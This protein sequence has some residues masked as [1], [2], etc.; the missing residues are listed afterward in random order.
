MKHPP[1]FGKYRGVVSDNKDPKKLGRIKAIV[2]DVLGNKESGWAMPCVPYAGD[3][4]GLFLLPPVGTAV[5]IEF[6]HGK[7]EF[8][9]WSG[10]FWAEKDNLPAV[11]PE[12]KVLKTDQGTVTLND[13]PGSGGITIETKGGLKIIMDSKGIEISN[14]AQKLMISSASVSINDGALEIT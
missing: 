9:V 7:T 6:E 5:W 1:F 13:Q 3:G 14:G 2:Q 11:I 12:M 8:P 10:C 4:V